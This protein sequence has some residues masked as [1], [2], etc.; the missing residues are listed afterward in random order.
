MSGVVYCR[1][2]SCTRLELEWSCGLP[3]PVEPVV[4][5]ELHR[6]SVMGDG[7]VQEEG[8]GFV[9][10]AW[11]FEP[12]PEQQ[13]RSSH[14]EDDQMVANSAGDEPF[15]VHSRDI[16]G[17][18]SEPDTTEVL[19]RGLSYLEDQVKVP[20]GKAVGRLLHVDMW[21]TKTP[22]GRHH[23]AMREET[24]PD[25]VLRHCTDKFPDSL[26]FIVNVELP[27]A[28]NVSVVAYWLLPPTS[29]SE[30][31]PF[32][33]LVDR[34]C[35]GESDKFRDQRF[36]LVPN[37][38]DGPWILQQVMPNR[39]AITGTKLTQHYFRRSNYFELDLD[40]SSSTTAQ[41]VGGLAQ[42]WA[43]Y[44]EMDLYLTIQGEAEDELPEK[45]LGGLAFKQLN[46]DL[47]QPLGD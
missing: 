11:S 13:Q 46:L 8:M 25:S 2:R 41:Y 40:V 14:P 30:A 20:A 19:V 22:E 24:R 33:K 7:L 21:T 3:H 42:S 1:R 17:M 29:A 18:W 12:E 32:L 10:D 38:I 47:A 37:L 16:R 5:L 23:I 43:S 45:I 26:V 15:A 31:S 35:N 28:D 34:F 44:L 39:P 9:S 27:N 6:I 36:K 4:P